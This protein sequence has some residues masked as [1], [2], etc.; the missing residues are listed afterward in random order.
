[1]P[2]PYILLGGRPSNKYLLSTLAI[3]IAMATV[4]SALAEMPVIPVCVEREKDIYYFKIHGKPNPPNEIGM[5]EYIYKN[6]SPDTQTVKIIIDG[7]TAVVPTPIGQGGQVQGHKT[8]PFGEEVSFEVIVVGISDTYRIAHAQIIQRRKH[9]TIAQLPAAAWA[10]N[11]RGLDFKL[12]IIRITAHR[13]KFG[14]DAFSIHAVIPCSQVH[15]LLHPAHSINNR[16][17]I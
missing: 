6:L 8:A 13:Q 5:V 15:E 9:A 7:V 17:P 4:S 3:V 10:A 2:P 1:M 12:I 11:T 14:T 16:T